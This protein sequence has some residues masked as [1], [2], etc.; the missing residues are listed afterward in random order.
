MKA[1]VLF[2]MLSLP[3]FAQDPASLLMSFASGTSANPGASSM[4]M[5]MRQ[6]R[7]WHVM[8]HGVAFVNRIEQSGP[9]GGETKT[10]STNWIMGSASRPFAGGTLM[11]RTMLSLEPATI[12]DRKYPLLFQTGETAFGRAIIDGQHPHDF[13]MEVAAAYARPIS[14]RGVVHVYVAPVGDPALGPVAFPHR[15]S[16]AELPQ[17]VLGHHYQ[18]STHIASSVVTSGVTIGA[19]RVEGSAF[20]GAEPDE[21]RW[22]F[23]SGAPDSWSGRLTWTPTRNLSAQVSAAYLTKP[24]ALDPGDQ[25][26]R[27]ASISYT[28]AFGRG[29]WANTIVWGQIYKES[30]DNTLSS[31]LVESLLRFANRH[32]VSLRAE[33]SDKDEL[34]PHVHSPIIVRP[35]PSVPTFRIDAATLGYTF[36]VLTA[37]SWRAGIGATYTVYQYPERLEPF[38]GNDARTALVFVRVRIGG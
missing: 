23:D 16:A 22:D 8:L 29:E 21:Q 30:L 18:D 9:R 35:A 37:P 27:T 14:P 28:R 1:A 19:W 12:R 25:K 38:Y 26:R 24:E 5:M 34:F 33:R 32:A 11:L 6:W 2:V 10:F 7:E 13:F 3:L 31:W 17:A 36:D 20:H 15:A 4:P